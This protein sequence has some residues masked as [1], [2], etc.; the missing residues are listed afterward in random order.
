M[1]KYVSQLNHKALRGIRVARLPGLDAA[2]KSAADPVL[3]CIRSGA[4]AA[5]VFGRY[6]VGVQISG[7][8]NALACDFGT[9]SFQGLDAENRVRPTSRPRMPLPAPCK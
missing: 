3:D 9:C 4:L 7:V 6:F 2:T 1:I 8:T 5:A